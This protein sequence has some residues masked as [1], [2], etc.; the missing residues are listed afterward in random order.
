MVCVACITSSGRVAEIGGTLVVEWKAS[1]ACICLMN[2]SDNCVILPCA[3]EYEHAFDVA[4][5]AQQGLI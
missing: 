2:E 4:C 3:R 1:R 5:Y